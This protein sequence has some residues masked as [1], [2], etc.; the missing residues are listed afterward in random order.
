VLL[1]QRSI[2]SSIQGQADR[3]WR[4][5]QLKVE[6]MVSLIETG[7]NEREG[8]EGAHHLCDFAQLLQVHQPR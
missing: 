6:V 7:P 4:T 1:N 2:I 3:S 5:K 8:I